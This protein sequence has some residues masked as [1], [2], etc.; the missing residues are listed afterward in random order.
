MAAPTNAPG[1]RPA[2]VGRRQAVIARLYDTDGS[3]REL[4]LSPESV[5]RLQDDQLLWIDVEPAHGEPPLDETAAVLELGEELRAAVASDAL[6]P[7][8]TDY[9][10]VIHLR[11]IDIVDGN[12]LRASPI[13]C[14]IGKNWVLTVHRHGGASHT[15]LIESFKGETELGRLDAASFLAALL[16]GL[17]GGY[18]AAVAE[19][20]RRVDAFDDDALRDTHTDETRALSELVALRRRVATLRGFLV[21]HRPAFAALTDPGLAH[22]ASEAS[23]E[24]YR[25][26]LE[27]LERAVDAVAAAREMVVGSFEILM[28][29]TAQRTNEVMKVL[30]LI[31]AVLLPSSVI[32]GVLGMNFDQSFFEQSWLFWVAVGFMGLLMVTALGL[33]RWRRWI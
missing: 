17:V 27:R 7:S 13:D 12:T 32:A 23:A 14:V 29:R 22:L 26:L 5:S 30:T 16:E 11:V 9:T 21:L 2:S 18:L 8:L 25:A 3:D 24:R 33:A 1:A 6:Q 20:E 4:E 10:D 31:S 15:S 19:T 28:T